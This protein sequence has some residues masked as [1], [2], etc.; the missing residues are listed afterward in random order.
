M[1]LHAKEVAAFRPGDDKKLEFILTT[2]MPTPTPVVTA[3]PTAAPQI[4]VAP[5][6]NSSSGSAGKG[7]GKKKESAKNRDEEITLD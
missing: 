6:N 3:A 2:Q 1:T 5:K 7:S 4:T